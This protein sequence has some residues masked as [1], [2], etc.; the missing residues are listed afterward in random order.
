MDRLTTKDAYQ[1]SNMGESWPLKRATCPPFYKPGLK[2][3]MGLGRPAQL[4]GKRLTDAGNSVSTMRPVP[5]N[6]I[7]TPSVTA[8]S[9]K[10]PT[11]M[12]STRLSVAAHNSVMLAY[13]TTALAS[14]R[15]G[16]LETMRW[17]VWKVA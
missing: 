15:A 14:V 17:Q 8:A 12:C 13:Q 6:G 11:D 9:H 4:C 3:D 10:T 2:A 1:P 7:V 16:E 5:T